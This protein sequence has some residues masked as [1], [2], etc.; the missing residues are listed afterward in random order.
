LP[1]SLFQRKN[2]SIGLHETI[3]KIVY[4]KN[5]NRIKGK[6]QNGKKYPGHISDRLISRMYRE[7]LK[8]S[9]NRKKQPDSKMNKG[10]E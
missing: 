6:P 1:L 10:L 9:N 2:R 4:Q 5:I 8:L 3:L 7:L